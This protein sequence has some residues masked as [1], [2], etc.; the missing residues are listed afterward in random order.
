MADTIS[1]QQRS[2]T[3]CRI[4][5]RSNRSTEQRAVILFRKLRLIGWRR[6][7]RLTGKPDFIFPSNRI[8]VFIDGCFW[9]G[10]P[11]HC[12]QPATNVD[13][14]SMKIGRNQRRDGEVNRALKRAGWRVIRVWECSLR[15]EQTS[16]TA[17]RLKRLFRK[18]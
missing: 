16:A 5:S 13:Y 8:A 1:R 9:H 7:S 10:C 6:N 17:S 11:K 3:M 14:W 2:E 18:T 12:R 4:L 15:E